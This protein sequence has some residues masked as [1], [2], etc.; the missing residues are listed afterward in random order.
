MN[1]KRKPRC[2]LVGENGNIFNL[3]GIASRVLKKAGMREEAKEM[4][5]KVFQSGSYDE[6]LQIIMEYVD[7]E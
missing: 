1:E 2:R 5:E 7:V 6:A 4:Q 3:V